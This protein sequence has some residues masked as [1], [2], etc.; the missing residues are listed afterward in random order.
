M[1]YPHHSLSHS[2]WASNDPSDFP[3][4]PRSHH[5][6]HN[7]APPHAH[8]NYHL[9]PS[10]PSFQPHNMAMQPYRNGPNVPTAIPTPPYSGE[11]ENISTDELCQVKNFVI[12][13]HFDHTKDITTLERQT[14][15]NCETIEAVK[16]IAA[17][18]IRALQDEIDQLRKE[19]KGG[20][21]QAGALSR[22]SWAE[23]NGQQLKDATK[24]FSKEGIAEAY[25]NEANDFENAASKLREQA[26]QFGA[27]V[28]VDSPM[29]TRGVKMLAVGNSISAGEGVGKADFACCGKCFEAVENMLEHVK[30]AHAFLPNTNEHPVMVQQLDN[31]KT[32]SDAEDTPTHMPARRTKATK[33]NTAEEV[34]KLVHSSRPNAATKFDDW[35]NE[36]NAAKSESSDDGRTL[37]K[38]YQAVSVTASH[39]PPQSSWLP[40]AV[41]NMGPSIPVPATSLTLQPY[42]HDFLTHNLGGTQ[43]SP[44][45]H[46]ISGP[47]ELPSKSYWLLDAAHEPFLPSRPGEHGAKL[48]AF[49]NSGIHESGEAPGEENFLHVPVFVM[50][51]GGDGYE[52]FGNYSQTRFSDKLDLERVM[53]S[54]PEHVRRFW[55]EQ[56]A[57]PGRPA[58]V[59]E[60]LM[61]HFWPKPAYPGPI[62][63][64]AAAQSE[65]T[66]AKKES[67]REKRLRRSLD[68]YALELKGWKKEAELKVALLTPEA[69]MK[70]F[71]KA[72]ADEEPGLRLWWEYLECVEWDEGFVGFLEGL[73]RNPGLQG[74]LA[75]RKSSPGSGAGVQKARPA[76][77]GKVVKPGVNGVE[78]VKPAAAPSS[79]PVKDAAN[80]FKPTDRKTP[81]QVRAMAASASATPK[82]ATSKTH[83]SGHKPWEQKPPVVVTPSHA[84]KPAHATKTPTP[85]LLDA[86]SEARPPS[87]GPA[88]APAANGTGDLD[89]AKRMQHSFTKAKPGRGKTG[90]GFRGGEGER[91]VAP[92]MRVRSGDFKG[93]GGQEGGAEDGDGGVKGKGEEKEEKGG[94]G[95]SDEEMARQMRTG[96]FFKGVW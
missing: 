43:Y 23:E 10:T 20:Q 88:P 16:T 71:G 46:F 64:D 21:Q 2:Q 22:T 52:Y 96:E 1:A 31:R 82:P 19:V 50:R 68:A 65:A 91:Y 84:T 60:T 49:F 53:E 15:D 45:F 28:A 37:Y 34:S 73:R 27:V 51:E 47:S 18:D 26:K 83:T 89:L 39:P 35:H 87:P 42:T 40:L 25:L 38:A 9:N 41:R 61:E 7:Q 76:V 6:N 80:T 92:H 30:D 77:G 79:A 75:G 48:T 4:R 59:T 95:M 44:G 86:W 90:F 29:G 55:A 67:A 54:V 56:L 72:D 5:R 8:H 24:D 94:W 33:D 93:D 14:K 69:L 36:P 74:T 12:H 85:T 66:D 57:D 58:W 70:A 3:H 63:S 81:S 78:T 62:P 13:N 17:N 32:F 11:K